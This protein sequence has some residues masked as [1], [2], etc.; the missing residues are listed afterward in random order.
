MEETAQDYVKYWPNLAYFNILCEDQKDLVQ[1][2]QIRG[3]KPATD[4]L[5]A[6]KHIFLPTHLKIY[7]TLRNIKEKKKS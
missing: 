1:K 6:E 4:Y 7:N 2:Y 3:S 5:K